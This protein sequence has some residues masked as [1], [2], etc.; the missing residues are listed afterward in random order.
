MDQLL[1]IK[2]AI[3]NFNKKEFNSFCDDLFKVFN[4]RQI[5]TKSLFYLLLHE[6]KHNKNESSLIINEIIKNIHKS[7]QK[8]IITLKNKP[9]IPG[10]NKL[11]SVIITELA[12]YLD[13][14]SYSNLIVSN[15][16]ISSS[17]H[18][19]PLP[20]VNLLDKN[21]LYHFINNYGIYYTNNQLQVKI[22][23]FRKVK[24]IIINFTDFLSY[25][26]MRQI[27]TNWLWDKL[28]IL[29]IHSFAITKA[30][31]TP[32][33]DLFMNVLSRIQ[34]KQ[35]HFSNCLSFFNTTTYQYFMKMICHN[36]DIECLSLPQLITLSITPK[37]ECDYSLLK[38]LKKLKGLIIKFQIQNHRTIFYEN[39]MNL[40][41]TQLESIH[42]SSKVEYKI[43]PNSVY[44]HETQLSLKTDTKYEKLKELCMDYFSCDEVK[45]FSK[46]A[47]QLKRF[48]WN[49]LPNIGL[50]CIKNTFINLLNS[51]IL[52][53][54]V[55]ISADNSITDLLIMG[56][57]I[58]NKIKQKKMDFKF[59]IESA[60]LMNCNDVESFV[61]NVSNLLFNLNKTVIKDWQFVI[62]IKMAKHYFSKIKKKMNYLKLKLK[63]KYIINIMQYKF[64]HKKIL[65]SNKNNKMNGI[66]TTWTYYCE[67]C[68]N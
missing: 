65:I 37:I 62:I 7:R 12:S 45:F 35:L 60:K 18:K 46:F 51:N 42:I 24:R 26:W 33:D 10:F 68:Y 36:K 2:Y 9:I 50:N 56:K 64:E 30:R 58:L 13:L 6:S 3:D 48:H 5:I 14:K 40:L 16:Y 55:S 66:D 63:T 39:L 57:Q 59:K 47:Y 15:R 54:Y 29:I 22:N 44:E 1:L 8:K 20:I 31:C 27:C 49:I 41:C 32:T 19:L 67:C 38:K 23:S 28:E 4:K 17:L 21:W 11:S 43:T 34:V 53:E 52:L 61:L 25:S